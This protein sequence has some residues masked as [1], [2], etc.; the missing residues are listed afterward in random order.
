[1]L[2]QKESCGSMNK[3]FKPISILDGP[4]LDTMRLAHPEDATQSSYTET[5][6]YQITKR[7]L[8]NPD[9]Y[10]KNLFLEE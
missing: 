6:H 2:L 9:L 1:M 3:Y 4:L 7:F 8:D 5:S 10:L